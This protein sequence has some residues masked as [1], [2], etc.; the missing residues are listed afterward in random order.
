MFTRL[1]LHG[2]SE[3]TFKTHAT[4]Y[5]QPAI[6]ATWC[7]KR[8]HLIEEIVQSEFDVSLGGDG[9]ADSPGFRLVLTW[10]LIQHKLIVYVS[11]K[12]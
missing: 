2:I 4:A 8:D 7:M 9:R 3:S 11:F 10:F 1:G 12:T 6:Y 5:L